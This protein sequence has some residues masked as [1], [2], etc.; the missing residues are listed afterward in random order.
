MGFLAILELPI[1][2]QRLSHPSARTDQPRRSS[3]LGIWKGQPSVARRPLVSVTDPVILHCVM[4]LG[5]RDLLNEAAKHFK[6]TP[7]K[8]VLEA[9][10]LG[11]EALAIFLA[12]QPPGTTFAE[13]RAVLQRNTHRG[14]H[15]SAVM[16]TP[17]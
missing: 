5:A 10:R 7:A 14:R 15:R 4:K 13:A 3:Y 9:E 8:R 12:T 17:R 2:L 11:R 6:G 16:E 1:E